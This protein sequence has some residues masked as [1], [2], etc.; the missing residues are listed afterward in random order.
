[1]AM[2]VSMHAPHVTS[3]FNLHP[4]HVCFNA[5]PYLHIWPHQFSLSITS[6]LRQMQEQAPSAWEHL[7]KCLHGVA[8]SP[9]PPHGVMAAPIS[10]AQLLCTEHGLDGGGTQVQAC[11]H[12]RGQSNAG[13][14]TQ[15][16]PKAFTL[17]LHEFTT[18]H[19]K[20]SRYCP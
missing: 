20:P 2:Q 13:H 17:G 5:D 11:M 14:V 12:R 18:T 16:W 8:W 19:S 15:V 6:K 10:P 9:A 4:R 7:S 3:A 1:M